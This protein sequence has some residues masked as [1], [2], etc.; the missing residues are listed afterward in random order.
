L[1]RMGASREAVCFLERSVR[2]HTAI[3]QLA[4]RDNAVETLNQARAS[5]ADEASNRIDDEENV[6]PHNAPLLKTDLLES[7]ASLSALAGRPD[8][9]AA[10]P[11]A[12]VADLDLANRMALLAIRGASKTVIQERDWPDALESDMHADVVTLRLGSV[13]ETE[14]V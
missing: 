1:H 8:L 4:A 2:I 12:L 11:F 13:R 9:L 7:L 10:E 14:F 3:G 6:T 5:V